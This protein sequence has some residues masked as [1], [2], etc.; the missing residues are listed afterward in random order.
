MRNANIIHQKIY[1][2]EKLVRQVLVW[3]FLNKRIVFTNG[4]FDILHQGHIYS[5]S[6]AAQEG[7]I[8]IVGLN[9]DSSVKRLNKGPERPINDQQSRAMLMASLIMVD[10]VVLFEE[11]TPYELI[12]SLMPD[13]LVK[14]GDYRVE[15][16]VGHREILENG[17]Q[18]IINPIVEGFSTTSILKKLGNEQ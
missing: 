7:D 8:L 15:Q 3:K 13:V 18:V 4:V 10:A 1:T 17:G 14:G 11:D 12:L 5:L 9:A 2:R 6:Q 16:V